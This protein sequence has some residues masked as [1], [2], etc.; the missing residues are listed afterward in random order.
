MNINL[1]IKEKFKL[2][3]IR[4]LYKWDFDTWPL[5]SLADKPWLLTNPENLDLGSFNKLS[6]VSNSATLPLSMKII[7]SLSIMVLILCAMV[8]TVLS[9]NSSR[10]VCWRRLSVAMSTLAVASSIHRTFNKIKQ[11]RYLFVSFFFS[12]WVYNL[13]LIN[14]SREQ[15]MIVLIYLLISILHCWRDCW[16]FVC[17]FACFFT[18]TQYLTDFFQFCCILPWLL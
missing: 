15:R 7:R 5:A 6:G 8:N 3:S 10:I 13:A 9:T 14:D 11:T 2:P 1:D 16:S 17:L 4:C 18:A 12:I